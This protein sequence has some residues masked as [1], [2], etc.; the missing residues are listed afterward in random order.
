MKIEIWSDIM[1]PFCYIGKRRFESA[2]AQFPRK[3]DLEIVWK[4]YQLNPELETVPGRGINEYLS[5]V[6]GISP[7]K[8]QLMNAHVTG[9]AAQEGLAFRFDKAVVANTFDAHRLI[10][11]AAEKGL[12]DEAEERLFKGYF[13]EGADVGDADTLTRLAMEIGLQPDEVT[14][15]LAT[16]RFAYEVKSD[17]LEARNLGVS[18]VPFFVL[19]SKYAIS[20]AQP[21][22]LFLQAITQA[23]KEAQPALSMVGGHEHGDSCGPDGCPI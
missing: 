14:A 3:D 22:E 8:A 7:D 15:M 20:G 11:L 1:C 4:S 21:A 16:D 23:W 17:M 10:H 19:D 12:Q 9:M 18:G 5:E 13:E 2:L 6:K